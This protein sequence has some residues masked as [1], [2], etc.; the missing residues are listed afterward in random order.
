MS[1]SPC[2]RITSM[3][4][5]LVTVVL[6]TILCQVS[7]SGKLEF[8]IDQVSNPLGR[9]SNGDCCSKVASG[10][11]PLSQC[12]GGECRTFAVL[13]VGHY[14]T[15][16]SQ[17]NSC[18]F[19][20]ELTEVLGA[21]SFRFADGYTIP[22]PLNHAWTADFSFK[23][24]LWNEEFKG[25]RM[26]SGKNKLIGEVALSVSSLAVSQDWTPV[27]AEVGLRSKSRV[28]LAYRVI[29]EDNYYGPQC[30]T[31]CVPRSDNFGHFECSPT[32]ERLCLP[33]WTGNHTYCNT[34]VCL[35]GCS[36][37]HGFCLQPNECRCRPG[38]EGHLCDQCIKYPGCLHGTCENGRAHTCSC[39]EGWG[40]IF[41]NQDL[42]YC[43]NHKP[44]KNGGSCTNSGKGSY[45]C[46]CQPNFTGKNCETE[47]TNCDH[48]PCQN[49]ATCRITA[50]NSNYTCEC[51]LGFTGRNCDILA[52]ACPADNP[53]V[54]GGTCIQGPSGYQCVCPPGDFDEKNNCERYQGCHQGPCKNNG[55]CSSPGPMGTGSYQ[56]TCRPGFVGN[57]CEVDLDDCQGVTCHNGGT[58]RDGPNDF[59]CQC[60]PGFAGRNCEARVD[61]CRGYPCA[62]GG[63]CLDGP[64]PGDF[65]CACAPGFAGKQCN[66][67]I[68]ECD[69][70]PCSSGATCVDRVN[71][72]LCLCPPGLT[73]QRCNL[74]LTSSRVMMADRDMSNSELLFEKELALDK[75]Q[76]VLEHYFAL[77]VTE[78]FCGLALVAILF[79]VAIFWC[80]RRSALKGQS[81]DEEHAQNEANSR[82]VKC[83]DGDPVKGPMIVNSLGTR[84]QSM[85]ALNSSKNIGSKR[86]SNDY[87]SNLISVSHRHLVGLGKEVDKR[88]S[89]LY[90]H[91]LS[92]GKDHMGHPSSAN[93]QLLSPA[94][95]TMDHQ[96]PSPQRHLVQLG[97]EVDR[98]RHY[99]AKQYNNNLKPINVDP[100]TCTLSTDHVSF[101]PKTK[102]K[103]K[104]YYI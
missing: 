74:N 94:K 51:P 48:N 32:G 6:L 23:L 95:E 99:S 29:C 72:F 10:S 34:S 31:I 89:A 21:N 11:N 104:H 73:G 50:D 4:T 70:N 3:S 20:H 43:T 30:M 5:A 7:A 24:Q 65:Q 26:M 81:Y 96:G 78:I 75:K 92:L 27:V 77:G 79:L 47:L 13:C 25:S 49:G 88:P 15:N 58:C 46:T 85:Y 66:L 16:L 59:R 60:P 18:T 57:N 102:T 56:C 64:A 100:N 19:G 33:G 2:H 38:Y 91:R 69:P 62:N 80:C 67:N 84:T 76:Q 35:P 83:L 82:Q 37:S 44:C 8:R 12:T 1:V 17:S 97:K 103:T 22:V 90:H 61:M 14:Q 39:D 86:L 41:C 9:D 45:T 53:C 40:G 87:E 93:H 42:N 98:S 54:N 55:H 36:K 68:D 52:S 71:E 101:L 63:T 28:N